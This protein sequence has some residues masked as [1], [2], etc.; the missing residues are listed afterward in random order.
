MLQM[1]QRN[2]GEAQ[3]CLWYHGL[4]ERPAMITV[5]IVSTLF[6]NARRPTRGIFVKAQLLQ[7]RRHFR[8]RVISPL[9][10]TV[11]WDTRRWRAASA[12]SRPDLIDDIEVWYRRYVRIP[13][14]ESLQGLF[15]CLSLLK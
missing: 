15:Y 13:R 7:L 11:A 2:L 4:G 9:P 3:Q 5:L 6:P 8:L 14:L 10:W 1:L 12:L